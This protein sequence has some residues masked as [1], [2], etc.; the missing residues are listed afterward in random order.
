MHATLKTW[1]DELDDEVFINVSQEINVEANE[2]LAAFGFNEHLLTEWGKQ[3]IA[4]FI[5]GCL[6]IYKAKNKGD[7]MVFYVWLDDLA[8]QIRISAV[9][10]VHQKLPFR[11]ELNLCSLEKIVDSIIK[12]E[13][14]LTVNDG[15]LNVWQVDI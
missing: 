15:K 5:V 11:C 14:G 9:S 8:G 3:S 10:K 4:D 13:S 1:L 6:E 2:N 7:R 12:I